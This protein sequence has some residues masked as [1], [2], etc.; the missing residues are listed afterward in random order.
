MEAHIPGTEGTETVSDL[1]DT[2]CNVAVKAVYGLNPG[3]EGFADKRE[4]VYAA[5]QKFA[6]RAKN[7]YF[8]QELSEGWVPAQRAHGGHDPILVRATYMPKV[9]ER[10]LNKSLIALRRSWVT[11]ASRKVGEVCLLITACERAHSDILYCGSC[12]ES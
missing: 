4:L 3:D 12:P 5:T 6:G 9:I 11:W 10:Y 7:K 2:L 1:I 8:P